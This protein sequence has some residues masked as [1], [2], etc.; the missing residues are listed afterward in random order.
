MLQII[1][2][3]RETAP[4]SLKKKKQQ[5]KKKKKK[6]EKQHCSHCMKKKDHISDLNKNFSMESQM[7]ARLSYQNRW[8]ITVFGSRKSK[9]TCITG[10]IA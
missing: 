8:K 7:K 10:K 4:F 9:T 3:A 6:K 5:K 1:L 2:W